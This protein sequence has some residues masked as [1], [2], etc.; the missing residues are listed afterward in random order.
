MLLKLFGQRRPCLSVSK[1]VEV[2][3]VKWECPRIG[4]GS[5]APSQVENGCSVRRRPSFGV[6]GSWPADGHPLRFNHHVAMKREETNRDFAIPLACLSGHVVENNAAFF[7]GH[8]GHAGFFRPNVGKQLRLV[9]QGVKP[10]SDQFIQCDVANHKA[11]KMSTEALRSEVSF[12]IGDEGAVE[13]VHGD[14]NNRK[15]GFVQADGMLEKPSHH[16]GRISGLACIDDF[17]FVK[18]IGP[19]RFFG[20]SSDGLIVRHTPTEHGGIAHQGD[21]KDTVGCCMVRGTSQAIS[22]RRNAEIVRLSGPLHAMIGEVGSNL[23]AARCVGFVGRSD[24]GDSATDFSQPQK[25]TSNDR[26]QKG[27]GDW[28]VLS[29]LVHFSRTVLLLWFCLGFGVAHADVELTLQVSVVDGAINSDQAGAITAKLRWLGEDRT[30]PLVR[31]GPGLWTGVVRGPQTRTVGVEI[32]LTE[33]R[34]QLRVSQGLEVLPKGDVVLSWSLS[35]READAA[36]RLSEPVQLSTMR[37]I[38]ERQSMLWGAWSFGSV[39][40]IL[41]LGRRALARSDLDLAIPRIGDAGA[42]LLWLVFAV[43]WTWPSILAGPD[44][45]GRHFDAMGTV[46]VIDAVSRLG[47]DLH[48]PFSAWPNGATYSAIDSWLLMPISLIGGSLDPARVHGWIA[49]LGLAS[50]GYAVSIFA[51]HV[52]ASSPFHHLAGLMFA[53]SGLAAAAIL[54]GHVYQVVNPWMPLMALF[55][56]R[57]AQAGA[58]TVDGVWAGIFFG[59]ALFSSGYL[60][61][62]AGLVGLGLGVAALKNGENRFPVLVSAVVA[63][64]FGVT[65]LM[66]F[67][68]AGQPGATHATAETLRMGSLSLNSMGPASAEID[69][70][71]HSWSLALSAM[72]FALAL[73]AWAFRHRGAKVLVAISAVSV[74]VAM[75]PDWTLGIAPDEASIASPIQFLWDIP[76]ARFL[77]FPGRVLW[78]ALLCLSTLAAVGVSIFA[79]RLG[80]QW[81]YGLAAILLM[82]MVI[83]VR[84]PWRQQVKVSDTPSAYASAQGAVFDLTGEGISISREVDSWMNAILCQYQTHHKQPIAEDCVAVGPA[85]NPRVPLARWV[86]QR[87]YEGDSLSVINRLKRLGFSAIAVHYDWI[88]PGDRLRLQTALQGLSVKTESDLAEAV[89]VYRFEDRSKGHHEADRSPER[90]VGPPIGSVDWKLRVDLMVPKDED[91]GRFFFVADASESIELKDKAGLPGDQFADGIYSA[92]YGATVPGEVDFRLI[93]VKQGETTTMWQG[94][95]VPLRLEEDRIT[96]RMGED[97]RVVP[98]LRALEI[99]SPEVRN[100]GGKIGGLAWL[101]SLILMGLWWVRFRPKR[102]DQS[103]AS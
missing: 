102:I 86:A 17:D 94:P 30:V 51:R 61:V 37:Q 100:R 52:G 7:I 11:S 44:I 29:H 65:Y 3:P 32:W 33:R 101:A 91:L 38:Q 68:A 76:S 67:S 95:V 50:S 8:T 54:E 64:L 103:P 19:E 98:H 80:P 1:G 35:G 55:L 14:E 88:D 22:V 27:L 59:L 34:P 77:R 10:P 78:A 31:S 9:S 40:M 84:L 72:V 24:S 13:I 49:V 99:F 26:A 39:L 18:P 74:L 81:A 79:R 47:F 92:T 75:G 2:S 43:A 6:V 70:T 85:T 57:T 25:G 41:L 15:I 96:F 97:G 58:R 5:T 4:A 69:R 48:D 42:A 46:W 87:L 28:R 56:W 16:P 53:G 36:W 83:C 82:E 12:D 63:G 45:V 66:L 60:G 23:P 71:G 62:S 90:L 73:M 21:T 20:E 89:A 93:Q